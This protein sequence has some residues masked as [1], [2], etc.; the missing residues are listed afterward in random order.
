MGTKGSE[1]ADFASNGLEVAHQDLAFFG[2][3]VAE[4]LIR[5]QADFRFF[6]MTRNDDGSWFVIVGA[7]SSEGRP[8]ICLAYGDTLRS[9]VAKFRARTE[10]S[11]W[12]LDKLAEK[13]G[14]FSSRFSL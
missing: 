9:A 2:D 13:D 3:V 1:S 11:Y 5:N 10:G 4:L 8:V 12:Q 14:D 6:K 7:F